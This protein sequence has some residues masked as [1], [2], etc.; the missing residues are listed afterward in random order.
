MNNKRV[1]LI[2]LL[3]L[4]AVG[5]ASVTT[6]LIINN[7]VNISAK[8][9]DFSVVFT[10]ANTEEDSS[11]TISDDK[12]VITYITKELVNPGDKS[13]LTYVI[14]NNSSQYDA[15]INL[16]IGLDNSISDFISITYET[17]DA[18]N[19]TS[20]SAKEDITGKIKIELIKPAIDNMAVS[21]T[22]TFDASAV[23]RTEL[24]YD[25]YTVRFN[26][27]GAEEGSMDE[28]VIEYNANTALLSNQFTRSG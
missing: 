16:S 20:L 14:K 26:G 18:S 7:N 3:L 17:I 8:P 13:E 24:A 23:S 27:N 6:N 11:A 21:L 22:V 19:T 2:I 28:Q 15:D 25:N 5:F 4:L 12:K 1:G 10:S 9:G